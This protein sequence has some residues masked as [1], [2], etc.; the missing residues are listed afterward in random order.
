MTDRSPEDI[1][2][3]IEAERAALENSIDALGQQFSPDM[4]VEKASE[5]AKTHGPEI[6]GKAAQVVRE[7]PVATA[8]VGAGIAWL[9]ASSQSGS[10][11]PQPKATYDPRNRPTAPG[12]CQEQPAMAEFDARVA[13]A[14]DAMRATAQEDT[15][16]LHISDHR[17]EDEPMHTD[18]YTDSSISSKAAVLRARIEDGTADMSSMARERVMQ[19]RAA[20]IA[21]QERIE[22]QAT[23]AAQSARQTAYEKP[24]LM[25]ALAFAAGA[26]LA[27][28]IPRTSAENRTLGHHRD[29]LMDEA[30]RIF[31]EE[32][33]KLK[34]A[35]EAAIAEGQ[36]IARDALSSDSETPS[37]DD[38]VRRVS[39]T[40]KT[41]ASNAGVGQ[42]N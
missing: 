11:Q 12:L 7:N 26:A 25:G 21:A 39:G 19:A 29:R 28:A 22:A 8:M 18:A 42:V 33:A 3:E 36:N 37:G 15:V 34:S 20:A 38:A 23:Q 32:T 24:L 41:A 9:I 4:V 6:A 5:F 2:R 13:R 30:D 16:L 31:R 1:E 14:D 10:A 27:M 17:K 35:A 40:A